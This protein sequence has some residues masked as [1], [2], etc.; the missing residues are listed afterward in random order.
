MS[1]IKHGYT[2]NVFCPVCDLETIERETMPPNHTDARLRGEKG[3]AVDPLATIAVVADTVA[4][5]VEP[6]GT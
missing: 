2:N 1:C 4:F 6:S 3:E 5:A